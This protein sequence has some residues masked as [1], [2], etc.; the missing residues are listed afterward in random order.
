MKPKH[1]EISV[2]TITIA[3]IDDDQMVL[4]KTD[5]SG[6]TH[7]ASFGRFLRKVKTDLLPGQTARLEIDGIKSEPL[8]LEI[9][10]DG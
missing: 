10:R 5:V 8:C 9:T 3:L 2:M 1:E 6:G 4:A 7:E